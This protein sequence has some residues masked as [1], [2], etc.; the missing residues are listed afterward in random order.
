MG[1]PVYGVIDTCFTLEPECPVNKTTNNN[2]TTMLRIPKA[3]KWRYIRR[4]TEL[5]I[6]SLIRTPKVKTSVASENG[7]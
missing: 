3:V 5:E 1:I 2:A 6:E 4:K 7:A